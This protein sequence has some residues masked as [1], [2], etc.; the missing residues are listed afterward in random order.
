ML[1]VLFALLA[2]GKELSQ[3][4][5]KELRRMNFLSASKLKKIMGFPSALYPKKNLGTFDCDNVVFY[6]MYFHCRRFSMFMWG[7][8][9]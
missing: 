1:D 3:K 2:R 7:F 4:V 8:F 6:G 9:V 5:R